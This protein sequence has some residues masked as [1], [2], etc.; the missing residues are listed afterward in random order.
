MISI[1]PARA[2]MALPA[3]RMASSVVWSNSSMQ[4]GTKPRR[5]ISCTAAPACLTFENNVI[6]VITLSGFGISCS[7]MSPNTESVPSLPTSRPVTS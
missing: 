4:R 1:A 7:V 2:S 6:I 5:M 3:L